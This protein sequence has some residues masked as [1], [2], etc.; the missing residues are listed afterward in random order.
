MP[1]IRPL[2][3]VA[4]A[5]LATGCAGSPESACASRP[6]PVRD[7]EGV[8]VIGPYSASDVEAI[9]ATVQ[10]RTPD[11]VFGIEV[12]RSFRERYNC[13]EIELEAIPSD[14]ARVWA[15]S[16]AARNLA[17]SGWHYHLRRLDGVWT[18]RD[19]SVWIG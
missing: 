2:L 5:L 16:D 4:S 6:F 14:T 17:G 13:G 10:P 9:L 12:P 1:A 3:L 8:R 11:P 7:V 19:S 18:V 15:G